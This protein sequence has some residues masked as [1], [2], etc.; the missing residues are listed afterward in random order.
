[1]PTGT[2]Y[3]EGNGTHSREA[4]HSLSLALQQRTVSA[5]DSPGTGQEGGHTPTSRELPLPGEH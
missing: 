1:M 2:A 5:R 4:E 3:E